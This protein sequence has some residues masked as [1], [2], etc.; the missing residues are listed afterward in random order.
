MKEETR[1]AEAINRATSL[2]C[3]IK[4][5]SPSAGSLF[6]TIQLAPDSALNSVTACSSGFHICAAWWSQSVWLGLYGICFFLLETIFLFLFSQHMNWIKP[7]LGLVWK[8]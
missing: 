8:K 3:P 2:Q 7:Y 1:K 4:R 5:L 6:F